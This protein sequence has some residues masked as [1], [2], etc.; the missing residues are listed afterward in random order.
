MIEMRID[1]FPLYAADGQQIGLSF[2]TTFWVDVDP[3]TDDLYVRKIAVNGSRDDIVIDVW[4][5]Q[6][7]FQAI[8]QEFLRDYE[9]QAREKIAE[10]AAGRR[11]DAR[12]AQ[13]REAV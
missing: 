10:D 1:E 9:H 5:P 3:D 8:E 12:I 13:M 7:L 2:S 6:G 11:T 4:K